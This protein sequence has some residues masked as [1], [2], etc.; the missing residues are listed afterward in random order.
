MNRNKR[1]TAAVITAAVS[2]IGFAQIANASSLEVSGYVRQHLSFNLEDQPET[3]ED[4]KFDMSMAR[5]TLRLDFDGELGSIGYHIVTRAEREIETSYLERLDDL[6][7]TDNLVDHY[8]NEEIREAVFT[9]NPTKNITMN[10]GK[11]QLAWGETDFF[12]GLDI[13]HG[14][15]YSWRSFLE[16][17]NEE[18]RK[19]LIM[20]NTVVQ[21]PSMGGA[22]QVFVR[23]GWDEDED[24]GTDYS[25]YGGRWAGQP[26]KGTDFLD[27]FGI[28]YNYDHKS[29][30]TDDV[31]YGARWSGVLGDYNYSLAYLTG[32]NT[33]P[34]VHTIFNPY[35]GDIKGGFAEFIYPEVETVGLT[36]STY[37][38]A[39]DAV[40]SAEFA[41]TKDKPYNVGSGF[42]IPGFAGVIEKNVLRSMIRMDKQMDL[43]GFIGTS[44]P[45]LVSV[46]LFD[47]WVTNFDEDDDIVDLAG[48]A[49]KKKEHS[50]MITL[51]MLNYYN[52][53]R[54]K[55]E[56]A[57]GYDLSYGGGFIIPSIN[58]AYGDHWRVRVEADI[59][60]DDGDTDPGG[61]GSDETN[62][63]G[64]FSNN[65][66]LAIRLT[67]QF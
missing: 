49:A 33:D 28:K 58:F 21:M 52:N 57:A 44:R 2:A 13:V 9:V 66:Q 17:E 42:F 34:V 19:P 24:I 35:Q 8:N 11:Q 10:F 55:P 38:E 50:T 40:W 7:G 4:D 65:D 16:V 47:T 22:L 64:Y 3:T 48:Y 32:F 43:S 53:D 26:N 39:T 67:Y 31:T 29:G 23:P 1:K 14:F 15:D 45:S 56:L 46:Q 51:L 60:F 12:T 59:F 27:G 20:L 6:R 18:L 25:L 63:F 62:L 30:D 41:Y 61:N 36:L 5:T 37:S 54:I